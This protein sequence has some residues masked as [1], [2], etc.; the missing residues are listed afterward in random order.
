[1]IKKKVKLK[2]NII[3]S[4]KKVAGAQPAFFQDRF[5]RIRALDKHFVKNTKNILEFFSY[6]LLKLCFEW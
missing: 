6:I 3:C 5:S 1:M 2:Y 4:K